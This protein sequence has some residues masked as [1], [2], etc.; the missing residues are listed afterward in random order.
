M[1]IN[2]FL[3]CGTKPE[4]LEKTCEHGNS[5]QR[6]LSWDSNQNIVTVRE[7]QPL[8]HRASPVHKLKP[9]NKGFFMLFL[10]L[11]IKGHISNCIYH[12]KLPRQPTF[13]KLEAVLE[14]IQ[15][16]ILALWSSSLLFW[17]VRQSLN[18]SRSLLHTCSYLCAP[19]TSIHHLFFWNIHFFQKKSDLYDRKPHGGDSLWHPHFSRHTL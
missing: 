19:H 11:L 2:M 6:R 5:T 8:H 18:W 3:D 14:V 12:P 16:L 7:C 13:S 9:K 4:F 15:L 10:A 17:K 1:N